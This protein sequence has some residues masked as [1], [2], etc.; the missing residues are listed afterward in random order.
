MSST[1]QQFVTNYDYE[2]LEVSSF[3]ENGIQFSVIV[4]KTGPNGYRSKWCSTRTNSN[5]N[6][7]PELIG[8]ESMSREELEN[9]FTEMLEREERERS[10]QRD[11]RKGSNRDSMD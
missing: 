1:A 3:S 11:Q 10:E 2:K 5:P 4:H 9:S 7:M 8:F 6:T